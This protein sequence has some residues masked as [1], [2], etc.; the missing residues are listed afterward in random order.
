M[1]QPLYYFACFL[2]ISQNGE[3]VGFNRT[4]LYIRCMRT[5]YIIMPS[6]RSAHIVSREREFFLIRILAYADSCSHFQ[7]AVED[8][9][10]ETVFD[11]CLDGTL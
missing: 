1:T 11:V 6:E 2:F 7:I 9:L 5:L 4:I 8:A 10:A 3:A